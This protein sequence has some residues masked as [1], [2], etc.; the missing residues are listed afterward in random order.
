MYA[1]DYMNG[2]IRQEELAEQRQQWA[3]RY[4]AQRAQVLKETTEFLPMWDVPLT[5]VQ[6]QATLER[7]HSII[8]NLYSGVYRKVLQG[9]CE[10]KLLVKNEEHYFPARL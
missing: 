6:L 7:L 8:P 1:E 3:N 9:L 10:L 4:A 5:E 2:F